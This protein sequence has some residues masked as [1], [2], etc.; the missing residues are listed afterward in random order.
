MKIILVDF[1]KALFHSFFFHCRHLRVHFKADNC[2]KLHESG[3]NEFS[4]IFTSLQSQVKYE[5]E[6]TLGIM[7]YPDQPNPVR[8]SSGI[9]SGGSIVRRLSDKVMQSSSNKS[10]GR[11]LEHYSAQRAQDARDALPLIHKDQQ[12]LSTRSSNYIPSS[13]CPSY[14]PPH[15]LIAVCFNHMAGRECEHCRNLDRSLTD[16][17]SDSSPDSHHTL[18]YHSP[19]NGYQ[20]RS[21]ISFNDEKQGVEDENAPKQGSPSVVGF[22]DSRLGKLRLQMLGLWARTSKRAS[23]LALK[24]SR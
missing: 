24:T 7:S 16:P 23:P 22:W 18:G 5:Y 2:Q 3:Y 19:S 17:R 11:R 20:R 8:P 1:F 12:R 10:T 6:G 9:R 13:P 21:N 15:Q 14:H 4:R